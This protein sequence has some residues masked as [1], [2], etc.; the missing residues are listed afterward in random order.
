MVTAQIDT[1]KGYLNHNVSCKSIVLTIFCPIGKPDSQSAKRN[2][3]RFVQHCSSNACADA[4][5][6]TNQARSLG[7]YSYEFGYSRQSA[8]RTKPLTGKATG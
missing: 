8:E 4:D 6:L 3:D 5:H 7:S 1:T 2:H